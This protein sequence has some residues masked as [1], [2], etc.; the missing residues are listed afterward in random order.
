MVREVREPSKLLKAPKT[1]RWRGHFCSEQAENRVQKRLEAKKACKIAL[2][3]RFSLYTGLPIPYHLVAKH[4]R[5][6]LFWSRAGAQANTTIRR[7]KWQ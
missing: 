4:F 5:A 2:F 1:G 7:R 3:L 6:V